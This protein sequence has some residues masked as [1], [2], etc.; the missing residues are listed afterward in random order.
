[1]TYAKYTRIGLKISGDIFEG[2]MNSNFIFL[3]GVSECLQH[4][5]VTPCN[6]DSF[7]FNDY[8]DPDHTSKALLDRK[9]HNET[10]LGIDWCYQKKK[11]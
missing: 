7:I 11:K 4:C 1:M 6:D 5:H 8:N 3:V 9:T 2:V 10:V